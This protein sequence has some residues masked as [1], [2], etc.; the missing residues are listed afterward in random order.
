MSHYILV[1]PLSGSKD[2]SVMD[3]DPVSKCTFGKL[4]YGSYETGN[5]SHLS[6]VI[7]ST[8]K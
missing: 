7:L 1:F 5:L 8:G 3:Q 6:H 2:K 4:S